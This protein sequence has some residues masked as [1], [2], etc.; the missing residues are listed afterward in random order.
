MDV[1]VIP[2][3]LFR[4]PPEGNGN[5]KTGILPGRETD[6]DDPDKGEQI[7]CRQC[8]QPITG[9]GDRLEINGAH[10]HVFANPSGAVYEIG[11]FRTAPGCGYS[12]FPTE[13]FSWFKGYSWRIAICGMCLTHMG[14]LFI[15]SGSSFNG[16]ILNKLLFPT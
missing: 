1:D 12:G 15:S 14:W 3:I 7:L 9:P 11:C 8:F 16:L 2:G 10:Q 6:L 4:E 5:E 13:E